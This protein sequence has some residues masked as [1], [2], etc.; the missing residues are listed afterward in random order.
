[1]P[2]LLI[3]LRAEVETLRVIHSFISGTQKRLVC[4]FGLNLR[5][6]LLF[7]KETWFPETAFLPVKSQMF[8]IFLI[9][10]GAKITFYPVLQ[11]NFLKKIW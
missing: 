2:Y 1:M 11:N 9:I 7:E 10:R 6:V 3:V 5:F 4:K 8:A